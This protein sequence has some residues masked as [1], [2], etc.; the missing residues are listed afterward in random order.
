MIDAILNI[1]NL[2]IAIIAHY[3]LKL[4]FAVL[5]IFA[6]LL[7]FI[8]LRIIFSSADYHTIIFHS[9]KVYHL[10]LT[11]ACI[12]NCQKKYKASE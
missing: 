9:I 6:V 12:Y 4:P 8:G 5:I 10:L 2:Y 11:V 3:L 1:L 7:V